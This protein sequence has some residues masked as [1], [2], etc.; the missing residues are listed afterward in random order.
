MTVYV[1]KT[2]WWWRDSPDAPAYCQAKAAL[3]LDG[4]AAAGKVLNDGST[5]IC[6]AAG[7]AWIVA[8]SCTQVSS[9]WAG[10]QYNSTS[11]G[12]KCCISEWSA[13]ETRLISCGFTPSDWFVPSRSQLQNPGYVCRTKWDSFSSTYYWSSTEIS[14][15]DGGCM[16]Y[17]NGTCGGASKACSLVV[18]AFRCV[19]Y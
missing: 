3:R 2:N 17:T 9:A 1:G 14:A 6:V 16:S 13:L 18:R 15:T 5:I 10:G 19:T 4:A 11:V 12:S 7:I 8:P